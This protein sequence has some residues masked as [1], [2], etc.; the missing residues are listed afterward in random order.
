LN[1]D[2]TY[3]QVTERDTANTI[4]NCLNDAVIQFKNESGN[5]RISFLEANTAALNLFGYSKEEFLQL[6]LHNIF[7]KITYKRI[8]DA[9][10]LS[11]IS[12]GTCL[13]KIGKAFPVEFYSNCTSPDENAHILVVKDITQKREYE[14]Q[15][16][17]YIQEL[18]ENK[19]LMERGGYELVLLNIKLEESEERLKALNASKDKFF[20]IIAHDLKSPF[21]SFLGLTEPLS[22]DFD[23]MGRD[24]IKNLILELNKSAGNFYSL[25]ENL[26]NWSIVQT[27]RM[28][29]IPDFISPKDLISKIQIL[30][31]PSTAQKGI[32]LTAEITTDQNIYADWNMIE[33]VLRNLISNAIKFTNESGTIIIK[34]ADTENDM[35]EFSVKD[36]GIGMDKD[37]LSKL[38]RIDAHHT[39]LG[40]KNEKGTGLGLILCKELI[41]INNGKISVES[42]KGT[43]TIFTFSIPVKKPAII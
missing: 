11:N 12:E 22:E 3:N 14:E 18:H 2:S 27:G 36:S 35:V 29:F 5:S 15:L 19:D 7:D 13:N 34:A 33:T 10:N 32:T 28:D 4:I 38:F 26:L 20:S 16:S 39:T 21:T 41:E 6:S 17:R 23:D 40:T 8:L 37:S 30:F 42:R 25:L 43:G 9:R 31:N 1:L 24:E